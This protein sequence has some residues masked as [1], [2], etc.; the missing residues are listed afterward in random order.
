MKAQELQ[1]V[2][3]RNRSRLMT[4]VFFVISGVISATWASRIPEMQV[5]LEMNNAAWGTVL[6]ASPVG[7]VCGLLVA[8]W[9]TAHF[10]VKK[11]M[12]TSAIIASLLLVMA[13]FSDT[14][15]Q[16]MVTLFFMG[17]SRTI[18][19][20]S[21]NTHSLDVQK[22]YEK[23]IISTFHGIWS[24]A[25]FI[26]ATIGSLMI[27]FNILPGYHFL[28]MALLC[29][30][31]S[32][33]YINT[34]LGSKI[35]SNEK[36]PFFVM[37]DRFLFVLGMIAFC[38]MICENAIFDWSVNYFE[39]TVAARKG[40]VTT[41]YQSFIIAM[42]L[43]RL[44]GDR[45]VARFGA[46]NMLML[47][48]GLVACGFLFAAAFPLLLPAAIGFVIIGLGDSLIVPIVYALTAK[49][50]NIPPAYAIAAVTIVGY[51]G[52]LTGPLLIGF[53]SSWLGMQWTFACIALFGLIIIFLATRISK[54]Q[55]LSTANI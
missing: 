21:A 55:E 15:L 54:F 6:F 12:I 53:L 45:L 39:T 7:L 40:L 52:F 33:L 31:F 4:I 17:F 38:G 3:P 20:I 32:L 50:K 25:C 36:K 22:L 49:S 42:T 10:G 5:K 46:I 14:R 37:P 8:S 47:N 34:S 29:I 24:L 1:V 23:P 51:S 41:G 48:G 18:L 26:S 9:L 27:V 44:L 35:H 30:L 28:I 13:G 11:I 43:G 16:L 2:L 19:N